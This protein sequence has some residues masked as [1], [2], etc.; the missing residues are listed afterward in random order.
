MSERRERDRIRKRHTDRGR[1]SV[2]VCEWWWWR[3]RRYG[4]SMDDAAAAGGPASVFDQ[5][6]VC[7]LFQEDLLRGLH[8]AAGHDRHPDVCVEERGQ[9]H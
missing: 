2:C 5:Q 4:G 6:H 8:D 3:R 7:V 9:G 1:E